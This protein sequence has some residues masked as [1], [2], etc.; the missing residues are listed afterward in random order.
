MIMSFV[1]QGK[2]G[3]AK[4]MFEEALRISRKTRGTEHPY[5]AQVLNNLAQL[6]QDQVGL[7]ATKLPRHLCVVTR[8][9][10]NLTR[11]SR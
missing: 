11:Q 3:E 6:L 8:P 10:G 4:P 5:V 2:H 7:P 9:S 1:L